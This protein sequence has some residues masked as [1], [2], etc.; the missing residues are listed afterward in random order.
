M[1]DLI[2]V[3]AARLGEKNRTLQKLYIQVAGILAKATG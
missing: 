3:I 1:T 2:S